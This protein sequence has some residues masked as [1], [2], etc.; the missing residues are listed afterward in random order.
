MA[1]RLNPGEFLQRGSANTTITSDNGKYKLVMQD[2][3]N[4]VAYDGNTAIWASNT[5]GTDGQKAIMQPD[6]NF[7]LYHVNG[8]PLWASNTSGKPGCFIVMQNDG[9]LVIYQ[10]NAPVWATNTAGK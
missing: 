2:D 8:K 5:V 9:N 3:G 4:L 10:P 6:G 7:V 1:D